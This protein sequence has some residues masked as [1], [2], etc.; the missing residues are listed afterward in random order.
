[1]RTVF[2]ALGRAL[3]AGSAMLVLAAC[4]SSSVP[5]APAAA[6]TTAVAKEAAPTASATV[7]GQVVDLANRPL[8]NANV[9]CSSNAQCTLAGEVIAQDGPDQGVKTNANGFY[10]MRVSR[11]GGG[12]FLLNAS[13][14]GFGIVWHE[15]QL[16]DPTCTWDQPGCAVTVNFTLT[17]VD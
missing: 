1:M 12:A 11:S 3:P 10:Q 14:R 2:Q 13:A 6:V 5:T 7:R 16:P 15:V 9:E 17:P 8:A 4:G